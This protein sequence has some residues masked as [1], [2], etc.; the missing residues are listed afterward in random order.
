MG[1]GKS[2]L[3]FHLSH[4]LSEMNYKT[5]IIDLDPQC[6]LTV[7]SMDEEKLHNIWKEEDDFIDDFDSAF[8]KIGKQKF[9]NLVSKPK[10]IHFL[11]K[12][13]EDGSVN[14]L[15]ELELPPPVE[16]NKNLS[17]IPGRLTIH[18]YENKISERWA[19][20]YQ[21]DP[22]AI[23]TITDIRYIA[24]NYAKNYGFEYII[25]DT[26][27]NLGA[28]NKVII[29][30]VDGF[31]IPAFP[32]MFSLY[33]IRNI[34]ASLD[35]W[36]SEFGII[37][38]LI[39]IDKRKRFPE[40]FVR[41]LGYTIYNAKKYTSKNDKLALAHRNYAQQIPG[42]IKEFISENIRKHLTSDMVDNP[43]GKESIMLSHNTLVTMAQKYKTPMWNV[44]SLEGLDQV[45]KNTI[46]GN[47]QS[48]LDTREKYIEF[49]NDFLERIKTLGE[50]SE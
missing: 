38:S 10:T 3:A 14:S 20:L 16:I 42:T 6:N 31:L 13:T 46:A 12:P 43:I 40:Q 11:L 39:S 35:K 30:T 25:I 7:F 2:T 32:D 37:Y 24:E 5:L 9:E 19:G 50:H 15:S 49:T 45:D 17:L 4:T 33:G 29:S 22:L 44:P 1:V 47:R 26:S 8:N 18:K 41:F 48:Y 34:G 27:P 28:L 23:R 21:G 36:N